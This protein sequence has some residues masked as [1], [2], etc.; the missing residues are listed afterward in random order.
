MHSLLLRTMM[1]LLM[2]LTLVFSL[3]VFARG[4]HL[5]G[6]GFVGGLVAAAA[7]VLWILATGVGQA[8]ERFP[9]YP[10][11]IA[12]TGL[13]CALVAAVLPAA[14]GK[15]M[16][17]SMW[18]KLPLPGGGYYKLGT[19][20]LF[21]LGVYLVVVGVVLLFVFS[22]GLRPGRLSAEED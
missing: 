13:G 3:F 6:G 17:T 10:S 21:D 9:T 16:L 22:L 7:L 5:P 12:A 2:P 8:R 14:F 20:T 4:H 15:E 1:R 18:Y 11:R 19:T